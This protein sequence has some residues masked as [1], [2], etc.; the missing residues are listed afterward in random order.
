MCINNLVGWRYLDFSFLWN[1]V[2]SRNSI[3]IS[4][5]NECKGSVVECC[6]ACWGQE[7]N[8][9]HLK[10]GNEWIFTPLIDSINSYTQ[11]HWVYN[12]R[13]NTKIIYFNNLISCKGRMLRPREPSVQTN[14]VQL[15]TWIC[16]LALRLFP[17]QPAESLR[18]SQITMTEMRHAQLWNISLIF[19]TAFVDFYLHNA[20]LENGKKEKKFFKN[21]LGKKLYT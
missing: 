5:R 19:Q 17:W 9:Q 7:F 12:V 1:T 8:L 16:L 4:S 6:L 2:H 13:D 15:Q 20:S 3:N 14:V 11:N 21:V 18:L 10:K